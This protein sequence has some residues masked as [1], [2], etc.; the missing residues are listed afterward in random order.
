MLTEN[1]PYLINTKFHFALNHYN[2]EIKISTQDCYMKDEQGRKYSTHDKTEE[3]Y[4]PPNVTKKF[5]TKFEL[6]RS[7]HSDLSWVLNGFEFPVKSTL[8]GSEI[9]L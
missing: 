4:I 5:S 1:L 7:G 8:Y 6:P 2:D 9:R 3:Q